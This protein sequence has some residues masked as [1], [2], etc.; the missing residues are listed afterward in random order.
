MF[1]ALS[2]LIGLAALLCAI[3]AFLPLFG[4]AYWLII[5]VA[6]FGLLVGSL[7]R[8]KAGRNLNAFVIFVGVVRLVLG[9]GI[10]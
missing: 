5:P 10:F 4:W 3:P 2:I 9:H 7:S 6:L 1:N 8:H